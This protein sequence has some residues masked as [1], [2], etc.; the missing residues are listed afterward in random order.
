MT[1]EYLNPEQTLQNFFLLESAF[2]FHDQTQP[3]TVY[4]YGRFT[5][6]LI[7]DMQNT[8]VS[9]LHLITSPGGGLATFISPQ[10][11]VDQEAIVAWIEQHIA[12]GLQNVQLMQ[13]ESQIALGLRFVN[14][15]DGTSRRLEFS[16]AKLALTHAES[17]QLAGAIQGTANQVFLNT[18]TTFLVICQAD[19]ALAADW[20]AF[21]RLAVTQGIRQ[22]PELIALIN[23]QI[24]AGAITFTHHYAN[25]PSAETQAL[26]RSELVNLAALLTG[27]T[28]KNINNID[29]LPS[30][31]TYDITY[32]HS[33]PQRYLLEYDQDLAPLLSQLPFDTIVSYSPTPLPEPSRPD[34]PVEHTRCT[35]QLGF[36]ASEYKITAIELRWGSQT[37]AMQWPSFPPVTLE[38]EGSPGDITLT[39]TFADYSTFSKSLFWQKDITLWPADIGVNTVVFDASHLATVFA[40]I[41]GSATWIPATSSLKKVSTSFQFSGN[42]WQSTW[43]LNTHAE[44]LNGR[45][46]YR[47]EGVPA[48]HWS[49]K[50][51]SG[52]QQS[53]VSPI[54]LQYIK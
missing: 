41:N 53:T 3:P 28:L 17:S 16:E 38:N 9:A 27:N 32:S 24:D 50:Y 4:A 29:Q 22:T 11:P 12:P 51:E 25:S 26:V 54:V 19:G 43:L 36:K 18:L 20:L 34:K 52:P 21:L 46:E 33:V 6:D 35:V 31:I 47:W 10:L 45:I 48:S 49:K 15:A 30:Q 2:A 40:S 39:V 23:Q 37:Q 8:P 1:A 13:C 5:P 42:Q 44:N 7:L 14:S